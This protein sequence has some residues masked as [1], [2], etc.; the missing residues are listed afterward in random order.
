[1][2]EYYFGTVLALHM[3]VI[4]CSEG[5]LFGVLTFLMKRKTKRFR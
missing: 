4:T 2:A 5:G 3:H 1:M